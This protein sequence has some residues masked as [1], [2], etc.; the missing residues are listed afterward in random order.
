MNYDDV[1]GN[2][3]PMYWLRALSLPILPWAKP[4]INDL[5]LPLGLLE[6][7][8]VW[9]P[10]YQEAVI[11]EDNRLKQENWLV[12]KRS[13]LTYQ[14]VTKALN[15]LAASISRDVAVDFE[16][17]VIR[18]FFDFDTE[19]ALENWGRIL[20]LGCRSP[21]T[22][23]CQVSPPKVLT[24]ILFTIAPLVSSDRSIDLLIET[25]EAA[26]STG[27]ITE[28]GNIEKCY[29]GAMLFQA[30]KQA[31][32]IKALKTITDALNVQEQQDVLIWSRLQ[33]EAIGGL[34][35]SDLNYLCSM[36]FLR[37]EFKSLSFP[38]VLNK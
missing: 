38:S 4:F 5:E 16:Y 2:S 20:R 35:N 7:L 33:A 36:A 21:N 28:G 31:L 10:I 27:G 24:P 19:I 13:E 29:E 12:E 26:P 6:N 34:I 1:W 25:N 32:V 18:N 3:A 37:R 30:I 22:H 23:R 15:K 11:E 8:N 9:E 17:W 14:I